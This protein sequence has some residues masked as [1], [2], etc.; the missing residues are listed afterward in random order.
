MQEP[1]A[2]WHNMKDQL[3]ETFPA[4]EEAMNGPASISLRLHPHKV[5]QAASLPPIPWM[6]GGFYLPKKP[7]FTSDPWFHAGAYY[8]QDASSMFVA[9]AVRQ[10]LD[11]S[12]PLRVLDL[13]AAPGGKSTALLSLLSED[14]LLVANDVIRSRANILMENLQKWGYPN[15]V[16]TQ[17]DPV[18][19][20]S[21]PGFFDVMLVDAPCSGEGLFRKDPAAKEQWSSQ[22]VQ[23]CVDRQRRILMDAWDT[24]RPGGLLIYATCTFNEAENEENLA[25]LAERKSI[26]GISLTFPEHW[27]ISTSERA[28]IPGYRFYPHLTQGEGLFISVLQKGD[29]GVS[30]SFPKKMAGSP[31]SKASK[32]VREP[33]AHW[34]TEPLDILKYESEYVA[35]S[36][37]LVQAITFVLNRLRVVSWGLPMT[38]IKQRDRIPLHPLVMSHW[39]HTDTFPAVALDHTDALAYLS[40]Q[41][42][43]VEAT[44]GWV[45][46]TFKGLPLGLM[47]KVQHRINNYYP[48]HWRI[49]MKLPASTDWFYIGQYLS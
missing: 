28:G 25:W 42:I 39:Y 16:V 27:G 44:T 6:Q 34:L 29:R 17:A 9:E 21:L 46:P 47:K 19:F 31:V 13:C 4:F 49:R 35:I 43:K 3:A 37:N 14:S 30:F 7:L 40:R 32:A 10:T 24:L 26:K 36:P 18:D 12:Q 23:F 45:V 5:S 2:F 48:Q 33:L 8:V 1:Q 20:Q 11:L 22:H 15:T 38:E 41:S